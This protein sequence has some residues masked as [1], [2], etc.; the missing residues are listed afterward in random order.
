MIV[1]WKNKKIWEME[2]TKVI[3]LYS[4][5]LFELCDENTHDI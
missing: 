5:L 4:V 3:V 1:T 2:R